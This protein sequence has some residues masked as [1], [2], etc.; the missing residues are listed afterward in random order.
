MQLR[1]FYARNQTLIWRHFGPA[2]TG[3]INQAGAVRSRASQRK[4]TSDWMELEK[5]RGISITS[6]VLSFEVRAPPI[7]IHYLSSEFYSSRYYRMHYHA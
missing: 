1:V 5:Q 2:L 3:A 6:T 7:S 4:A